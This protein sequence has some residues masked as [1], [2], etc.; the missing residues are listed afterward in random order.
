MDRLRL[1]ALR[2]AETEANLSGL[3]QG[4]RHG[5]LTAQGVL[6]SAAAAKRLE[7]ERL[8]AIWCSDLQRA[9]DS[10]QPVIAAVKAP[11]K[12]TP[13]LRERGF[14]FFEDKSWEEYSAAE[15]A[16]GQDRYHF[17]PAGGENF[18][19]VRQ[20][21]VLLLSELRAAYPA[22]G[23]LL[24]CSHGGFIRCLVFHLMGW[25]TAGFAS[26]NIP[27][28]SVQVF[29]LGPGG[30]VLDAQLEVESLVG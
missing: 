1:L 12:V 9:L 27:N 25:P 28:T 29:V 2:H 20:R 15:K 19:D 18:C 13:L 16:S 5:R 30:A 6:Q 4:H 22:G 7:H 8:D 10:V 17:R 3:I 24:I 26:C 14:G 11:L 23:T 21:V